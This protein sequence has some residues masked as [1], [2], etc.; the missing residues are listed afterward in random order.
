MFDI[1]RRVIDDPSYTAAAKELGHLLTDQ[2]TKP[3]DRAIWWIEHA[4]RHP[5][6]AE[7]YRPPANQLPWYQFYLLDVISFLLFAIAVVL[8]I[9]VVTGYCVI[10][11]VTNVVGTKYKKD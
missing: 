4:V 11:L 2:E 5:N 6:L 1:F 7:H 9:T 8:A 3:L 10:R